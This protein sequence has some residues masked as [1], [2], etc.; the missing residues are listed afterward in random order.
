MFGKNININLL[1]DS[2]MLYWSAKLH[3]SGA[4][5][6]NALLNTGSVNSNIIK[7]YLKSRSKSLFNFLKFSF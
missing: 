4:D 3:V 1:A 6:Q 5:L 7:R 2:N